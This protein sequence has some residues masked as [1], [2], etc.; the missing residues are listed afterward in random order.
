MRTTRRQFL[1]GCSTAVA[2]MAGAR[3]G[4]LGLARGQ[5]GSENRETVVVVF[6]RGGMDGLSL[7]PP[8]DG[9]DR[10]HY[11]AAR[12]AL[13][14]PLTGAD[15]ALRL[16]D[17]F[18]FHPAAAALKPLYEASKL[19]IIHA[20]GSSGSRSHFDAQKYLELGTPGIKTTM[21][22]WLTRHL[23]SSPA[24]PATL[25]MPALA[26]GNT[27]PTSLLGSN[28]VV[29]MLDGS[30]FSLGSI[31]NPSWAWGDEWASLRRL[32]G[33]DTSEVYQAGVQALNAAGFVESYVRSGYTPS[34]GAVYPSG[35]FGNGLKVLAQLIKNEVGLRVATVDHGNWDTHENQGNQPGGNFAKLVQNLSDG[36]A[37]FY[38]DLDGSTADAPIR[39]VTVVVVSEFGRRIRENAN[40]GTDHGTANPVFVLGGNVTGGMFGTFPGLHPDLRYDNADLAPTVDLRRVLS[41]ILIRRAA[42]PRL[43]EVFPKYS[44]YEPMGIVSGP[45]LTPDYSAALPA[46]P[47]EFGAV[48][49]AE[50]TVQLTWSAGANA[51]NYRIERRLE[52]EGSW[53]H[54]AVVGSATLRWE[55]LS[56]PTGSQPVYRLQAVN[57][58]GDSG[59]IEAAVTSGADP[60]G[61]WR[62]QYFG[63]SANTGEAADEAVSSSDGLTNF[64]KYALGLDPRVP[65]VSVGQGFEPGRPR[66]EVMGQTVSMILVRPLDRLDVR[67]EVL[68]STDLKTWTALALVSEGTSNGYERLRATLPAPD[69]TRHFLK[70][71]VQPQ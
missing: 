16:T 8:I 52:P 36:L 33:M 5:G 45:D 59:Y 11:E 60:R 69:P 35:E 65:A 70:L 68:G 44:G 58:H 1:A 56:V 19:A 15:A 55:D 29:N 64:A 22:G 38:T 23:A 10:G 28:D 40:Y 13:K 3:L 4:F 61:A 63:T 6:L 47:A 37:A 26:A 12:P 2:A 32:Y 14:I 20:V 67:Y 42:N 46:T 27:P 51:T 57:S 7:L 66:M 18:G 30:G 31:G 43:G 62:Q 71:T 17:R 25:L 54:V 50:G 21:E 48:R 53:E 9:E 41:E 39:R 34:G 24:L 49:G